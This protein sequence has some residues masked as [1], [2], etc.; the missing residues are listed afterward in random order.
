MESKEILPADDLQSNGNIE[1]MKVF[2]QI[3]YNLYD[4]CGA[5]RQEKWENRFNES[6]SAQVFNPLVSVCART[7]G[8]EFLAQ[9]T[10]LPGVQRRVLTHFR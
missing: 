6:V 5:R 4:C 8:E 7:V 3:T 10:L 1:M 9:R 2:Q